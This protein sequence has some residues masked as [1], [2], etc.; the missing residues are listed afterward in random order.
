MLEQLILLLYRLY[1]IKHLFSQF[2]LLLLE[3][4]NLTPRRPLR[5]PR[6]GYLRSDGLKEL[7]VPLVLVH[8]HIMQPSQKFIFVHF[9]QVLLRVL[10]F[11]NAL[12]FP[13]CLHE[14]RANIIQT[15]PREHL[16]GSKESSRVL[17]EEA[18]VIVESLQLA[19][20]F[21]CIWKTARV[22]RTTQAMSQN[23]AIRLA[24]HS[25]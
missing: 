17:G 9:R 16:D 23:P 1:L 6:T 11:T 20:N 10:S 4:V 14:N 18:A 2:C 3:L 22:H 5:L 25:R 12:C 13:I 24:R 19:N 7:L 15:S 21:I 8:L